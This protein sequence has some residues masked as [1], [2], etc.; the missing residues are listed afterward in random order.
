[1]SGFGYSVLDFGAVGD[2]VTDDTAAI[3]R[4]INFLAER[5]GGKLFFPFTKGGYRIASPGIE[6]L[7]GKPLRSQLYIPA[8]K[9]NIILEGEMPC[10]MLYSYMVRPDDGRYA[11]TKFGRVCT[12]TRIFSDW[13]PPEEHDPT[14]RPWSILSAPMGTSCAGKFSVNSF[15]IR[16]LEF[17]VALDKEKMYPT[18]GAVNLGNV[19]RINICDSQFCL[20]EQIGDTFLGKQLQKNPCHVAGLVTSQD[21]TDDNVLRNV[22]V[23]GFKYGLVM[24]EHVVADYLYIHNCEEGV[25]F[26][27]CSHLS[28]INH[29][30]A[31]HNTIIV[32]TT[33]VDLYG[34]RKGSCNVIIGSVN[35]ESGT[36]LTPVVSQ[37]KYGVRDTENRLRGSLVWH[38]PWGEQKFPV[39]GAKNFVVQKFG[40]IDNTTEGK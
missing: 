4:G 32:S 29:I 7:N 20:N 5:G 9:H 12:N 17:A 2:G 21:Q 34:N 8:G 14:A 26:H 1:M 37:L 25:T 28:V 18:Q 27:D 22:A 19:S 40:Q 10:V 6:E 3:Q 24:S 31:Q 11:P 16:N 23:Q 15:S 39:L 30:V 36:G 13:N 33:D 35:F 38:E